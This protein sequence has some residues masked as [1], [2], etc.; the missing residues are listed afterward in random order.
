MDPT[1]KYKHLFEQ[2]MVST[3][4]VDHRIRG[5]IYETICEI[6]I[7]SKCIKGIEYTKMLSGKLGTQNKLTEIGNVRVILNKN[8]IQGT[9]ATDITIKNNKK[10]KAFSVKYKNTFSS[11]NSGVAELFVEIQNMANK[12]NIEIGLIIRDK[13]KFKNQ[14]LH[15][16]D[17][18]KLHKYIIKKEEELLF[19][20]QDMIT[21]LE[22]FIKRQEFN[23]LDNIDKFINHINTYYFGTIK[24]P[25]RRRLHQQMALNKFIE[26]IGQIEKTHLLQHKPR[27]GKS[28]TLLLIAKH[29]LENGSKKILIMTAVPDTIKSFK[30]TIGSYTDFIDIAECYSEQKDFKII[31]K[32]DKIVFTSLQYF[33]T[34]DKKDTES[35][36]KALK[37]HK[38]DAIIMDECHL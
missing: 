15:Q 30:N 5:F 33:K 26:N 4:N 24:V 17:L 28:I 23:E 16:S 1:I 35:K 8:I 10:I 7:F 34:T 31:N 18:T 19:D 36:K 38:F 27:S 21:G 3:K 32:K 6:L 2:L 25:L 37:E 14:R 22:D 9:N 12:D 29:L 20:K 13:N 11:K